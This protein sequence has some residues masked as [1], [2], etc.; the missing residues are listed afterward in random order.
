[1]ARI[2]RT[3]VHASISPEAYK[4]IDTYHWENHIEMNQLLREILEDFAR[5]ISE[6]GE[7][8]GDSED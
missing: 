7:L 4:L 8:P 2:K 3:Q 6:D 1:M 5:N